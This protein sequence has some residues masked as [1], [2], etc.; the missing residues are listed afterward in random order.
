MHQNQDEVRRL[1]ADIAIIKDAIRGN[2]GFIRRMLAA[3]VL[4][5]F[6]VAFGITCAGV[7]L[8]WEFAF[9]LYRQAI[10]GGVLAG[11]ILGSAA[12]LVVLSVWKIR[13]LSRGAQAIDSRYSWFI[14]FQ[15]L[16]NHPV[17]IYQFLVMVVTVCTGVIAV[18]SGNSYLLP[19]AIAVGMAVVLMLYAVS[20]MLN[21]YALIILWLFLYALA[22]LLLP[23]APSLV[24]AAVG[25][26]GGFMLYGVYCVTLAHR[27]GSKINGSTR[28]GSKA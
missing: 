8:G 4:G 6:F 24:M 27:H 1:E 2:N 18:R 16:M 25:F 20:F 21:E 19:A 3:P 28:G 5:W 14:V 23:D 17:I 9:R 15:D 26:G 13:V 7:L 22:V 11:L 10:P 12:L